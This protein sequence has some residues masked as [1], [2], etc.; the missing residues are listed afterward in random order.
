MSGFIEIVPAIT[1]AIV[2][3]V[4]LHAYMKRQFDARFSNESS[5]RRLK[6]SKLKGAGVQI[7]N[8]SLFLQH[9][10]GNF[11]ELLTQMESW[12]RETVTAIAAIDPADAEAF[13]WLDEIPEPKIKLVFPRTHHEGQHIKSH[14]EHDF[15]I[16]K[17]D[18][19]IDRYAS[20]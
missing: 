20:R 9:S 7:R 2:I 17:L 13:R 4:G 11:D 18:L 16:K 12:E 14:N 15:R 3:V 5:A 19:L 1:L 10:S 8:A 6:L